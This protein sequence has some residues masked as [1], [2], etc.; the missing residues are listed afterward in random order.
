MNMSRLVVLLVM[1]SCFTTPIFA[2]SPLS[3]GDKIRVWVKGEPDLT[4]DRSVGTDG[5][6]AF[7][8]L[9]QVG[10]AG[11]TPR[12]AAKVLAGML[13][14]GYLRNPVVQINRSGAGN[15]P[16][17]TLPVKDKPQPLQLYSNNE[18]F[19]YPSVSAAPLVQP[20]AA[21]T[22]VDIVDSKSGV[23][24]PNAALLLGGKIYQSNRKGQIVLAS[25]QGPM[26]LLADG[27]Q[28]VQNSLE[29]VIQP[30]A[31]ARILM[32]R[33]PMASE[34]SVKVVDAITNAPI[35]EVI[36]R[37]D[38]M[39]VKTNNQGTFRIKEIVKEFGELQLSKKGYKLL[40]RVLD[41][42]DPAER[43]I[44]LVRDN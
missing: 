38:G 1:M 16:A 44:P 19:D 2:E 25:D 28:V 13:D 11:M 14:D 7:P 24:V 33:V 35:P 15:N 5:S 36:V 20:K 22:R 26:I 8:L 17:T 41:F 27:Y 18:Q 9:G 12:E 37:L 42:K 10:V 3:A 43:V 40:K 32:Q 31:V 29:N 34:V 6:I 39:R 23:P 21:V 30:G 4:V